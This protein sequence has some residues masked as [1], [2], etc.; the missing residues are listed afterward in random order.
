MYDV[1]GVRGS[2]AKDPEAGFTLV[3]LICAVVIMGVAFVAVLSAM[4]TSIIVSD[5]HV[6]R[7]RAETVA[8]SWA[9]QVVNTP[10]QPCATPSTG[11]YLVGGASGVSVDVPAGYSTTI[12][13]VKYWNPT[14]ALPAQF[15]TTCTTDPGLQ[16]I[17]LRVT[18]TGGRGTQT[19][20]F[21]KRNPS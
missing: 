17:T 11:Q 3:E 10:Y 4:G 2:D 8:Q 9:E 1:A 12:D 16:Q 19:L 15:V 18:P 20:T 6:R 21:L 14:T 5:Y 7:A 13:S